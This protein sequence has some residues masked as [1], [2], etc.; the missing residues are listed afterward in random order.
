MVAS[1]SSGLVWHHFGSHRFYQAAYY[2][3]FWKAPVLLRPLFYRQLA[4]EV[5]KMVEYRLEY[6]DGVRLHIE[7]S[8]A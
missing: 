4:G 2:L 6:R 1:I 5:S 3:L 7:W 8:R